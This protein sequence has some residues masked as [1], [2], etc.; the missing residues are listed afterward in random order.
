MTE[1]LLF[2]YSVHNWRVYQAYLMEYMAVLSTFEVNSKHVYVQR[3]DNAY[4]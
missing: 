2:L 4:G 1:K 3:R